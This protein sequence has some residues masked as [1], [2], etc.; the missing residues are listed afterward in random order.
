MRIG[1]GSDWPGHFD[2]SHYAPL[3]PLRNIYHA[4]TRAPAEAPANRWHPREALTLKEA[5]RAYTINPAYASHEESIKGSIAP[6]KLADLV[7][8]STDIMKGRAAR[9]LEAKVV[10]TIL[11]GRIIFEEGTPEHE[12]P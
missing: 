6:G 3:D 1:I 9:L 2:K 11:D 5:I 12:S 4:I 10:V 7:V 8:L